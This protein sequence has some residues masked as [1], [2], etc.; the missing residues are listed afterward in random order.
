[1]TELSYSREDAT[2]GA[3]SVAGGLVES[4]MKRHGFDRA[5]ATVELLKVL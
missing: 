5:K 4:V 3:Q 1:M 2:V